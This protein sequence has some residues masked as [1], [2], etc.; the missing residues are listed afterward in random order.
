MDFTEYVLQALRL[1]GKLA[2]AADDV[3]RSDVFYLSEKLKQL[4][5]DLNN[6]DKHIMEEQE[7]K[8]TEQ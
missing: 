5:E 6:Y 4:E 3:L 7:L 1:A 2:S 8:K